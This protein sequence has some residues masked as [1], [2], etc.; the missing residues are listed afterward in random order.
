MIKIMTEE[1]TFWVF[2]MLI[3]SILPIDYYCHMVGIQTEVKVFNDLIKK[4]VP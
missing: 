3:E 2:A 4:Y 1:E